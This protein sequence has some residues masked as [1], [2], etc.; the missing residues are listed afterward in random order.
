MKDPALEKVAQV[1]CDGGLAIV[2]TDTVYGVAA[3]P[4]RAAAIE[5]LY[6]VKGRPD[7][8]PIPLLAASLEAVR[9]HGARCEDSAAILAAAFWP[10]PLTLVLPVDTGGEEG[11]RVPAHPRML[12]LLHLVGGVLRVTSANRSGEP[13]ATTAA[14]AAQA[15]GPGVAAVLDDGPSPGGVPSTVVR[16]RG[17]VLDIL[18]PGALSAETLDAAVRAKGAVA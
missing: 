18:R 12:A 15:L 2:P 10:G 8:K 5:A 14:E 17:A 3:H 1:L 4:S 7:H 6:T 13:P 9:A 11:F 16:A